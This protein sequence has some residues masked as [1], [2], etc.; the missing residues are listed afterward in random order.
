MRFC[1]TI[2]RASQNMKPMSKPPK[3]GKAVRREINPQKA[4]RKA[5]RSSKT[6]TGERGLR[7]LTIKQLDRVKR[8]FQNTLL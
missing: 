3:N 1:K 6:E 2:N 5:S 7:S 4:G 8:V